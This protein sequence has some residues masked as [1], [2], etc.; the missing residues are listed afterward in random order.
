MVANS[1]AASI[2][3]VEDEALIAMELEARLINFG[4]KVP[5]VVNTGLKAIAAAEDLKP[6]LILM[7]ILLKGDMDGVEAAECI[8]QQNA[9]PV[10]F[11]TANADEQ[12]I[13]R[14]KS[15]GPFGYLLKPLE[16]RALH[17]AVEIA[18]YKNKKEQEIADYR[19]QLEEANAKLNEYLRIINQNV[20]T[21]STDLKGIITSASEAFCRMS[22]YSLEEMIGQ[23]HNICRHPDTPKAFFAEMWQT[24][25]AG[26]VW[27]GEMKN[28]PRDG[29]EYWAKTII[30]PTKDQEGNIVGYTAIREDITDKKI[31]EQLSIT[32]AMT[33]LFNR[34]HFNLIMDQEF[35]RF[36]RDR[37]S[38]VFLIFDVDNFKLYNDTYGHQQGDK[39]LTFIGNSLQQYLHRGEDYGF[40]LGGEEF[41]IITR[42][43]SPEEAFTFADKYR[44]V[45]EEAHIIHEKNDTSPLLTISMGGIVVTPDCTDSIEQIV[46][47]AD[48]ALYQAKAMGRNQVQIK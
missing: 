25:H 3:V 15:V 20:L 8:Q 21:S 45:I 11:L 35:R 33:G 29:S 31:I 7:D 10:I 38:L 9:I 43:M 37:Q 22:G 24:L 19:Q 40:R 18:L 6:D 5:K 48:D 46:K 44:L 2:L 16:E 47:K 36:K 1:N 14:A 32:D 28:I 26:K 23:N 17:I 12:T 27:Q 39:A 41:G 30:S 4:Y 42:G 34:R 13:Q